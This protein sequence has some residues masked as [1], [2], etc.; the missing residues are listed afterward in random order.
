MLRAIKK[1]NILLCFLSLVGCSSSAIHFD[2]TIP[3][4]FRDELQLSV[5][6][7]QYLL[8]YARDLYDSNKKKVFAVNPPKE[9]LSNHNSIIITIFGQDGATINSL[10]VDGQRMSLLQKLAMAMPNMRPENRQKERL[11]GSNVVAKNQGAMGKEPV[12]DNNVYIHLLAVTYTARFPNFGI[13]GFFNERVYEPKVT[14]LAYEL[15]GKRAELS[16][17]ESVVKNLGPN[18]ARAYLAKKLKFDPRKMTEK[19]DLTIEVYRAQHFGERLRDRKFT[20]FHRGHVIL[21]EQDISRELIHE[22]L[23]LVGEWYKNNVIDGEVT[24]EYSPFTKK[25]FNRK[26]SMVRS[27]MSVWVLN[28]LA[29]YL[30]DP[31]LKELGR[32]TIGF[33]LERYFQIENSMKVGKIIPSSKPLVRGDL[34]KNR[35]TAA[36]FIA[37]ALLVRDDYKDY[38]KEIDLLN[39]WME[40]FQKKDG[41][42][43]TQYAGSQYFMP[44]QL[45]LSTAINYSKTKRPRLKVFFDRSYKTYE[46]AFYQM[47]YLGNTTYTPYAPG[48]ATQFVAAMNLAAPDQRYSHLIYSINDRMVEW[49]R[50]NSRYRVY[51]DYAGILTVKRS[52][53]GNVSGTAA[54]LESLTDAAVLAK[55]EGDNTRFKKY[56]NV[57]R[58]SV[59][60][61]LRLQYTEDNVYFLQKRK[62][63]LG[64]FK[65]DL[66]D[67]VIWMDSIWHLTSALIKIHEEELI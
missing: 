29:Y 61:L 45:L 67:G 37:A 15:N 33:Y 24:F 36:S 43:W 26:R 48:W 50:L 62:R 10:R 53:F 44:G 9:T 39:D 34:V 55:K 47:M 11:M 7:Q 17:I 2:G 40:S 64:A 60:Y 4:Q 25:Y 56:R 54:A 14:G 58:Q 49:F 38:I 51:P 13:K 59:A 30:D 5:E 31:E 52:N 28:K 41:V 18:G 66:V 1:F 22:R 46:K 19:N 42:F 3:D 6:A 23:R 21:S 63:V 27:T 65:K 35:Y 16:P 20:Q 12:H 8:E 57:L 32:Q